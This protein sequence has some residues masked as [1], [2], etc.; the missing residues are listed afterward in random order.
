MDQAV[1]LIKLLLEKGNAYRHQGDVF[2]DPLTFKGFGKLFGLDM[3][4]WPS[5]KVRF[6]K[7]TYPGQRWNLGDFILWHGKKK[8]TLF[9]GSEK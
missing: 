2:F 6:R 9:S 4:R 1:R 8:A 3:S 7:D 5:R